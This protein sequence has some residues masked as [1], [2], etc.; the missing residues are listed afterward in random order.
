MG[1][2]KKTCFTVTD[3]GLAL[4]T[5]KTSIGTQETSPIV[6]GERIV[7][8]WDREG[9]VLLVGG[10]IVKQYR[11]PSP[12]QE[13]V[14][15]AFQEEGWPRC[16]H[17]PLSPVADYPPKN[18][19]RET[20]RGLNAGQTNGLIRFRGDGTG[21]RVCWEFIDGGSSRLTDLQSTLHRGV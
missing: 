2:S 15:A 16:V 12:N 11:V 6:C 1:F 10:R 7:P 14:L 3:A 8:Y 18:R 13:A 5:G 9:R 4:A 20:I 17:D 19:L 21:E